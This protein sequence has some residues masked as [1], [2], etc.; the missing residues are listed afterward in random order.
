MARGNVPL[1]RSLLGRLLATALFIAVFSVAA[2]AW[3]SERTTT[4]AIRQQQG[5]ALTN[6]ATIYDALVGYAAMHTSWNDVG[7]TVRRLSDLAGHPITLTTRDRRP[8]AGTGSGTVR[9]PAGDA[10]VVD[11]LAVNPVLVADPTGTGI[12]P[13]VVGPFRLPERERSALLR[14]AQQVLTCVRA[15]QLTGW[16][17]TSPS[18]RPSIQGAVPAVGTRCG[19]SRLDDPTPTERKAIRRL[20]TLTNAC[21]ADRHVG[22]VM[23]NLDLTWTREP[24]T[25]TAGSDATV[26]DRDIRMCL[27]QARREQLTPYVA[28]AAL[29]FSGGSNRSVPGRFDL[30]PGNRIRLAEVALVVLLITMAVAVLAGIRLV[31]P[32]RTLTTAAERMAEGDTAARVAVG[33]RDELGRLAATF[34]DMAARRERL[35]ELRATMVGDVAHELRT[36][37]SNIRGWLEAAEDEVVAFDGDLAA[38]LLEEARLLQRIIEDLQDLAMADAD[39]LRLHREWARLS[40]VLGQAISAHRARAGEADLE[41]ILESDVGEGHELYV[42]RERLRQAV[43][44]LIT[45]AIRHTPPGGKVTVRCRWEG[46]YVVVEVADTGTGIEPAD[47]PYVFDRFWRAEKSRTR[48]AGGSGLGLSITRKLAEA[49][50]GT[51][52][53]TS[54]PGRGSTFTIRLPAPRVPTATADGL[55]SRPAGHPPSSGDTTPER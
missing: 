10:T 35:E 55:G 6:D 38:S 14:T 53:V 29:L 47:L 27:G 40:D 2:T 20:D 18:G 15:R 3:L 50:G 51:V 11:A 52:L 23:L 7:P 9:A 43:G 36:P 33:G 21:L 19:E 1:R 28:P 22:Q 4:G 41:L 34:N 26:A 42:D 24:W 31:R 13:R 12:D 49:H 17:V 16:I 5:R 48:T 25:V 8:I 39:R 37:L 46:E 54:S 44:N 30:S 45:N 32:L